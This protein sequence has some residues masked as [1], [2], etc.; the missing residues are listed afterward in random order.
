MAKFKNFLKYLDEEMT[1]GDIASVESKLGTR[2]KQGQKGK[3]C[4]T[5][6][7]LNC[8]ECNPDYKDDNE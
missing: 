7:R 1:S 3:K 5:H 6:K 2:R 8:H 4:K